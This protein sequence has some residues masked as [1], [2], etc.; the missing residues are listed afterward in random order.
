MA[1]PRPCSARCWAAP[2]GHRAG[3]KYP[4][5]WRKTAAKQGAFAA[6]HSCAVEASLGGWK[7]D[8]ID[9]YQQARLR[10]ADADRGN[11]S[12]ARDLGGKA[13]SATSAISNFPAWRIAEPNTSRGQLNV[14]RFRLLPGRYQPVVRDIEKDLLR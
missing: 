2:Q 9:L 7:T 3:D 13:K 11:A 1:A 10:S 6:L 4:S 14:N 5:R 8:Y 12:R